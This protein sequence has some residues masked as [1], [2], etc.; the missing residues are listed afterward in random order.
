MAVNFEKKYISP[1]FPLNFRKVTELQ[2]TSSKALRVMDKNLGVSLKT[3]PP[4]PTGLSRVKE[5]N[6]YRLSQRIFI[7]ID[8]FTEL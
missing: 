2:R 6:K 8:T 7:Q 5:G 3:P 1:C 4:P